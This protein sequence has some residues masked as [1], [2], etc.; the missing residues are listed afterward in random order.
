MKL[1]YVTFAAMLLV[2]PALALELDGEFT[3]IDTNNDGY[4]T[5]DELNV[6]Q[7]GT[8][9][10]QNE[11]T[12]KMLDKDGNGTVSQQEYI[13]FY[14][15]V[16]PEKDANKRFTENFKTL[17]ANNDG[18]LNLDELHNFREKTMDSTN[19]EFMNALD[20][21]HDGKVSR[22]E[23]DTFVETMKQMFDNVKF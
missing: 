4:I 2:S 11:K 19:E 13:D 8:L 9:S 17:D 3:S 10:E 6:A 18:I 16:S 12:L 22:E 5:P 14:T 1:S 20:T 15:Q 23:Y 7:K 21:N